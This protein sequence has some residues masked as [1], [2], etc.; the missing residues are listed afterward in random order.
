[1]WGL[2]SA[3]INSTE[4]GPCWS[5]FSKEAPWGWL[6]LWDTLK[7]PSLMVFL[8][9]LLLKYVRYYVC[10]HGIQNSVNS[11]RVQK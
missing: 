4:E 3:V 8:F 7:A 2:V 9:P 10:K 1:M 6:I 5:I 11:L